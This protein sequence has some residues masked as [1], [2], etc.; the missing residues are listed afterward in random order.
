[1]ETHLPPADRLIRIDEVLHIS[2]MS[3]SALYASIQKGEFPAQ[4]KL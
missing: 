4:V 1:M 2:R 3:R